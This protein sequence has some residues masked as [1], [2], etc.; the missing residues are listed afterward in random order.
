[1]KHTPSINF[2]NDKVLNPFIFLI[3]FFFVSVNFVFWNRH[4]FCSLFIWT[5]TFWFFFFFFFPHFLLMCLYFN[6]VP[7][8]ISKYF[9]IIYWDIIKENFFSLSVLFN[10]QRYIWEKYKVYHFVINT[11][12]KVQDNHKSLLIYIYLEFCYWKFSQIL[13]RSESF[14]LWFWHVLINVHFIWSIYIF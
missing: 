5:L 1:M 3:C 2:W 12:V 9:K 14:L 10:K 11:A 6:S 8:Q 13:M 7:L 4:F